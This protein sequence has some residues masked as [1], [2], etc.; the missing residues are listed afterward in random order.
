MTELIS[1]K[2]FSVEQKICLLKEL[3]FDSDG[4][5]VTKEGEK[6]KDRYTN[7]PIQLNNMLI[8]PGSTVVIDNNPLS[9]SLFLEEF[10]NVL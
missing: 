1:L 5:F 7:E 4:K 8:L 10:G 2:D 9:V 6:C 3:G